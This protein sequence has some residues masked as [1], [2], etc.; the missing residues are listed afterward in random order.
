MFAVVPAGPKTSYFT[1][2]GLN[3]TISIPGSERALAWE[4]KVPCSLS[5]MYPD[6][7]STTV[8][9]RGIHAR[10]STRVI[11]ITLTPNTFRLWIHVGVR[12]LPFP[13]LRQY[14]G[15]RTRRLRV[16]WV[17]SSA[18]TAHPQ[19]SAAGSVRKW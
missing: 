19:G 16:G 1:T 13:K 11:G 12:Q 17:Y 7:A 18:A 2:F 6:A 3:C 4:P 15:S 5:T 8:K 14:A 9:T 10:L